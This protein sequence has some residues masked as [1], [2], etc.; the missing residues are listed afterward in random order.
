MTKNARKQS[1]NEIFDVLLWSV[2]FKR[3]CDKQGVVNTDSLRE[4]SVGS[5]ADELLDLSLAM[6]QLL[7]PQD[8]ADIVTNVF[9]NLRDRKFLSRA[10][11][12]KYIETGMLN[13]SRIFK[14]TSSSRARSR[15]P[16]ASILSRPINMILLNDKRCASTGRGKIVSQ[17]SQGSMNSDTRR[18]DHKQSAII[19]D[20]G[21]DN[22]VMN[23]DFQPRLV[24]RRMS[25]KLATRGIH[26]ERRKSGLGV[27]TGLNACTGFIYRE[28]FLILHNVCVQKLSSIFDACRVLCSMIFRLGDELYRVKRE[29]AIHDA[30]SDQMKDCTFKP[31]I[32]NYARRRTKS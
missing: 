17:S 3:K 11:F 23:P 13:S 16:S 26:G 2:A 12:V 21:R 4:I 9:N 29:Q 5:V 32:S 27:G 18:F 1:L 8:L 10:E 15:S 30:A 22:V 31:E 25:E 28:F 7:Q 20:D 14:D 6:P 24:A 19:I